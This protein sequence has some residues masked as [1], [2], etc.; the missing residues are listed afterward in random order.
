MAT[1]TISP[2]W[3]IEELTGYTPQTTFWQDFSIADKFGI[4][5]VRDTCKRAFDEWKEDKVYLTELSLVLNWKIWQHAETN[6][7][8]ARVY[9]GLW[10]TIDSWAQ[11]NLQEEALEYYYQITD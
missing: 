6:E 1:F 2:K 3:N 7:A 4:N 11:S 10:R 5:A 9:D 8:L